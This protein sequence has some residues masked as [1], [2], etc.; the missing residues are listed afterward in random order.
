MFDE[1]GRQVAIGQREYSHAPV[2][3]VPGSQQFDTERNWG[4]I[5]ECIREGL[6]SAGIR[7]Q[8][9]VGVSATSMRE[10]MVCYDRHDHEI[11][12]CPNVDARAGTEV[13]ELVALGQAEEIFARAGD[14]VAI[15][16]PARFRW[17]ARHQ[18]EIFGSIAHVGMLGDWIL[19]R[20][21]GVHVTDP[22]LGSSSGMFELAQ[23]D[24]SE[25]IIEMCGLERSV[26]PEVAAPGT[27]I[28]PVSPHAAAAT[29]LREGTPVVVGGADT[30]LSLV[31]IGVGEPGHVTV[32]GGSFWQHTV[33]L[34]EPLIDPRGRLRTLCHTAPGQ[35][36]MEGIGFYSGLTLRWFRDAFYAAE[37]QQSARDGTDVYERLEAEA[38]N[39]PAGSDGVVGIFSNLME[40]KRWVHASPAFFGFDVLNPERSGRAQCV[41][42]IEEGA[43]YV[44]CGHLRIIEELLGRRPERAVFTGG[45]AKGRLWPRIVADVLGISVDIPEVKE[46]S[47]LGAAMYAGA[48]VG[49]YRDVAQAA[50]EIVRFEAP[51]EPDP[52][53]HTAYRSLYEAWRELYAGA[54]EL[55]EAGLAPALWRAAG[56]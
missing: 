48:A 14:W 33:L 52:A 10:G 46:S 26:F 30:Q 4:L 44:S 51:V 54:L 17:I 29:G 31:G 42:A 16:A 18:P 28:G 20:L 9:V 34:N 45:A 40:A 22:S 7:P 21:C 23:R 13:A 12:A 25:Y 47:A 39:V 56:T 24:W 5:C 15:T 41:R 53:N 49:V 35:W 3:G 37:K 43:A 8:A 2:P 6:S 27:L 32:V 1:R 36:M 11:W 38:A 19:H 50:A 55:S